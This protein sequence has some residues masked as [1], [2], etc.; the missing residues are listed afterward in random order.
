[1]PQGNCRKTM[2]KAV[3]TKMSSGVDYDAYDANWEEYYQKI[4]GRALRLILIDA[5]DQFVSEPSQS[6]RKAIALGC[7]DGTQCAL[8]AQ[9]G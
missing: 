9:R 6:E 1:M 5:L 2:R 4:Y 7:G 8:F 3:T